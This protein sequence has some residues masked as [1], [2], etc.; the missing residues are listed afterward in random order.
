MS[1]STSSPPPARDLFDDL[2]DTITSRWRR[3]SRSTTRF[4]AMKAIAFVLTIALW[5]Y[6]FYYGFVALPDL[7]AL[8][9]IV[10]ILGVMALLG[11]PFVAVI[12]HRKWLRVIG[13]VVAMIGGGVLYAQGA[14][15]F[16]L[17]ANFT[18][19]STLGLVLV[20][21]WTAGVMFWTCRTSRPR[22]PRPARTT[23][24]LDDVLEAEI[25]EE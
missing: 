16:G 25:V 20:V 14:N 4:S 13:V 3:R 21:L 1:T 11:G 18:F 15:L 19:A 24:R 8:G 23:H 7:S 10:G 22:R 2:R 6:G 17:V 5:A 9:G 12:N